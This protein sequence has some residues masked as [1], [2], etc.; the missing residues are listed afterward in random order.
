MKP[1]PFSIGTLI[2]VYILL[3][4]LCFAYWLLLRAL[5]FVITKKTLCSLLPCNS[6][7]ISNQ[8]GKLFKS[9]IRVKNRI[10]AGVPYSR[11]FQSL[12]ACT[13]GFT[14]LTFIYS[15]PLC[16]TGLKKTTPRL[17]CFKKLSYISL[18]I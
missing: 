18:A 3:N 10:I 15:K 11:F 9:H 6:L 5:L 13:N 17:H 16:L 7:Q 4:T 8:A 2:L 12:P 1:N 14:A